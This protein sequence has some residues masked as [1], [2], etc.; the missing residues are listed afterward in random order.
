MLQYECP[1]CRNVYRLVM[2]RAPAEPN[3]LVCDEPALQIGAS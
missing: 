2:Q 1:G 3:D